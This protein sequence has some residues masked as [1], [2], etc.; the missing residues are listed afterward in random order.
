M[1]D[2]IHATQGIEDEF[3]EFLC[4]GGFQLRIDFSDDLVTL[5]YEAIKIRQLDLE[6]GN[7]ILEHSIRH[8]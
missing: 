1:N 8:L 2:F 7:S 3:K 4:K 5:N 6:S